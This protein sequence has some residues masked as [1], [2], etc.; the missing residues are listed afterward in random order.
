M[1]EF[2]NDNMAE[3]L[4]TNQQT[5]LELARIL[6]YILRLLQS[7]YID[8]NI[9]DSVQYRLNWVYNTVVR[10]ADLHVIDERVVRCIQLAKDFFKWIV[11]RGV[12]VLL[13]FA[14]CLMERRVDHGYKYP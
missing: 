13:S 12:R 7:D 5:R 1:Q 11:V 4:E 8:E 10:Y 2:V 6:H 3:P 9:I 14:I